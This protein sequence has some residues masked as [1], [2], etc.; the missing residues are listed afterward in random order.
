M[1]FGRDTSV[2]PSN[3]VLDGPQTPHGKGRVWGLKPPVC[4]DVLSNYPDRC[5]VITGLFGLSCCII[6]IR[7]SWACGSIMIIAVSNKIFGNCWC[8]VEDMNATSDQIRRETVVA[9]RLLRLA[10]D[11]HGLPMPHI[12]WSQDG[13]DLPTISSLRSVRYIVF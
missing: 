3:S 2:V 8:V 4:S 10:C 5:F 1:P 9:G 11:V 12:V 13:V 6:C 7:F